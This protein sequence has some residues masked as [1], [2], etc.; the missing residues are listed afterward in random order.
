MIDPTGVIID[1]AVPRTQRER[2]TTI[3]DYGYYLLDNLP[4]E[5]APE[6]SAIRDKL[7]VLGRQ[8]DG[9]ALDPDYDVIEVEN[10]VVNIVADIL[11]LISGDYAI[12]V[13]HPDPGDVIIT[14]DDPD[15]Y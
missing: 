10:D 1:G 2:I 12:V 5:N 4:P 13:G 14:T 11:G 9:D 3:I 15:T 7:Y 8:A 6:V